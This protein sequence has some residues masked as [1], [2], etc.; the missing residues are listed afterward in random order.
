MKKLMLVLVL[1]V[2]PLACDVANPAAPDF[3]A[4]TSSSGTVTALGDGGGIRFDAPSCKAI[5]AVRLNVQPREAAALI[6]ASYV[7][8]S[9]E[10]VGACAAPKWSVNSETLVTDGGFQAK[11]SGYGKYFIS[12]EAPNGVAGSAA[13]VLEPTPGPA[14]AC[15]SIARVVL[16]ASAKQFGMA[17]VSAVYL[18]KPGEVVTGCAAPDWTVKP[19]AE[20]SIDGFW[21]NVS[22]L[23]PKE[24][25]VV[26]AVA[27]NGVTGT[28]EM[29]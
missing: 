27:P 20:G 25:Y 21:F 23:D 1:A 13:F 28:L 4:A 16:K 19:F 22:G 14:D 2:L 26:Y 18:D 29:Q 17:S 7:D 5:A 3:P 10:P 15:K 9:G 6:S 11:V 12:A 24:A 8:G